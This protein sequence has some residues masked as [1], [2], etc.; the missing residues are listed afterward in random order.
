[1]QFVDEAIISI[2][3]GNGGNGC[4]S[5]LREKY[6]PH[7]GPNGGNG[8]N[9]GDVLIMSDSNINTLIDYRF[10]KFFFAENGKDGKSYNFTG[11]NGN[12]ITL[13]VPIGTKVTDNKTKK[14]IID[15]I[16]DKQQLIIAKG[17]LHGLGNVCFKSSINRTPREKTNG[18]EGE[19]REIKLELMLIADIGIFGMPNSGKSTLLSKISSAKPKIANYPFTTLVP[20]LGVI[21]IKNKKK[22]VIADIPGLIKG[23]SYGS[24]L[25]I[26]FLKHLERCSILLHLI[27]LAPLDNSNP[28]E[29][30][31]IINNEIN[32]YNKKLQKKPCL[33]VFN[34]IDLIDFKKIN[35]IIK[36]INEKLNYKKKYYFISSKNKYGLQN[37]CSD[38]IK[39]MKKYK[40]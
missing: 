11:K 15:M 39:Y 3:A 26:S 27:D 40:K 18:I 19:K 14:I 32:I 9:G 29:N 8:G 31:N 35:K 5:F 20:N 30:I 24:G 2:K 7:G 17:G 16:K 22:I 13:K 4:I 36:N 23:A 1:M 6:I 21:N 37:L 28:I 38:L 33:L 12:N 10:K 25:G 34:K